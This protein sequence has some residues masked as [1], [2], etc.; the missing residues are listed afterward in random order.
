MILGVEEEKVGK[1]EE[2]AIERAHLKLL[3]AARH[4][5]SSSDYKKGRGKREQRILSVSSACASAAL[6]H[7]SA[8]QTHTDTHT[9]TTV[10]Q[11]T[12]C[13]HTLGTDVDR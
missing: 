13:Q 1:G 8:L 12:K 9:E 7:S 6:P 5:K 2:G 4:Q 3:L 11:R 10:A